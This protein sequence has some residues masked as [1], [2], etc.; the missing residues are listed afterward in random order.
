LKDLCKF[1]LGDPV[2]RYLIEFNITY[3]QILLILA[4]IIT[5]IK[6]KYVRIPDGYKK[7]IKCGVILLVSGLIILNMMWA[8]PFGKFTFAHSYNYFGACLLYTTSIIYY[9]SRVL[10]VKEK[11]IA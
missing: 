1:I 9:F 3:Q 5:L 6:L 10:A 11:I 7:Q 8:F 4:C 2:N